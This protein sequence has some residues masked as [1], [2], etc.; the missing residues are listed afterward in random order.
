M[1]NNNISVSR[2][3][4]GEAK[5]EELNLSA[6]VHNVL[7]RQGI[8]TILKL[9]VFTE[10][11]LLHLENGHL[12]P[13]GVQEI[14]SK[15]ASLNIPGLESGVNLN[16]SE[17]RQMIELK[18]FLNTISTLRDKCLKLETDDRDSY[19]RLIDILTSN[20]YESLTN[21]RQE[22]KNIK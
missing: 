20:V 11:E 15:I 17:F 8:N 5:I 9:I 14:E 3:I 13:R 18:D 16:D 21:I 22:K 4:N 10:E 12:R 19:L 2:I 1:E 7:M 6:P